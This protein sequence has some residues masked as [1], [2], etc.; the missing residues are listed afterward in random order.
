MTNFRSTP[1]RPGFIVPNRVGDALA[2]LVGRLSAEFDRLDDDIGGSVLTLLDH[3]AHG[4]YD[5][6]WNG[7][8]ISQSNGGIFRDVR[9]ECRGR[10]APHGPSRSHQFGGMA[11]YRLRDSGEV[12]VIGVGTE[13]IETGLEPDALAAAYGSLED[14]AGLPARSVILGPTLSALETAG[15]LQDPRLHTMASKMLA[16]TLSS[17]QRV[18]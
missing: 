11:D 14:F 17:W 8:V 6:L 10:F 2:S 4:E 5:S 7:L 18:S 1:E 16:S 9:H 13:G 12:Y 3:S 15:R